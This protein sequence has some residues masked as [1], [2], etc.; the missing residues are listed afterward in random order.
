MALGKVH[1]FKIFFNKRNKYFY[2]C[3]YRQLW[4]SKLN[5]QQLLKKMIYHY[6]IH[7]VSYDCILLKDFEISSF[8]KLKSS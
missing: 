5:L 7:Y 4:T 8:L 6:N 3:A 1:I 2:T